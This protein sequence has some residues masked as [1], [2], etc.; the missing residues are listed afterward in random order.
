LRLEREREEGKEIKRGEMREK[1]EEEK[2]E[3]DM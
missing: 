2:S 1:E 3:N